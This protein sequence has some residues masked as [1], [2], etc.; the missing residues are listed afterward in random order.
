MRRTPIS[1]RWSYDIEELSDR[2]SELERDNTRTPQ[3]RSPARDR[4]QTFHELLNWVQRSGTGRNEAGSPFSSKQHHSATMR[5]LYRRCCWSCLRRATACCAATISRA[6]RL[7]VTRARY[8]RS[9]G[10]RSHRRWPRCRPCSASSPPRSS[11]NS[12]EERTG[13]T[14]QRGLIYLVTLDELNRFAPR[15]AARSD[16]GVDRA[17]WRRRCVRRGSFCS[18]RNSRRRWF[19]DASS[20]TPESARWAKAARWSWVIRC[21]V[22]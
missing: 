1:P 14:A 7:T 19:R 13:S 5:K 6:S 21:G 10:R 4:P 17:A 2:T 16:H 15:D 18:G 11:A 9:G 3:A 22:S 8:L 20:R 12:V